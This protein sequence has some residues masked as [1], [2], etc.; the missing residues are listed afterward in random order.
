MHNRLQQV[1]EVEVVAVEAE[2]DRLGDQVPAGLL[3]VTMKTISTTKTRPS[4]L[5]VT[6]KRAFM[7]LYDVVSD[8][9]HKARPLC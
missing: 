3:L 8:S 2:A 9:V 7:P 4:I 1:G 6:R 5:C